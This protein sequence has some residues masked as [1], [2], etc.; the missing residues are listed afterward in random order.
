[1]LTANLPIVRGSQCTSLNISGTTGPLYA[2]VG[3]G[4]PDQSPVQR[5]PVPVNRQKHMTK[6]LSSPLQWPAINGQIFELPIK[7]KF[8]FYF[9]KPILL[10]NCFFKITNF[11][12]TIHFKI[13]IIRK[14]PL[15]VRLRITRF[16]GISVFELTVQVL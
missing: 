6:T 3:R 13:V 8:P 4:L 15:K 1:M 12:L 2:R 5:P 14:T 10:M 7:Q 11:E 9:T 16:F